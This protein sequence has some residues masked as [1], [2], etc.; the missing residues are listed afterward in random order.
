MI[1]DCIADL[2]G[3]F[4]ELEGGDLLIDLDG[5][6]I[7]VNCSHVDQY[8]KPVNKPIRVML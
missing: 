4:P 6:P 2:H 3:F 8:Y 7:W 1:I 5:Y